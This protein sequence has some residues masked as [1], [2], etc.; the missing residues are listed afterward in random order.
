MILLPLLLACGADPAP[1][2]AE[3]TEVLAVSETSSGRLLFVDWI[4]GTYL[5][6]LCLSELLPEDCSYRSED[7][8]PPCLLFASVP[9]E[10]ERWLLTMA[11]RRATLDYMPGAVLSVTPGRPPQT[12]WRVDSLS[13]AERFPDRYPGCV[14]DPD[15]TLA[16]CRLNSVHAALWDGDTLLVADTVNSRALWLSTPAQGSTTSEVLAIL[17]E[18]HAEW[19]AWRNMNHIQLLEEEGRSLLLTTFKSSALDLWTIDEGRI[20]LW[21]ITDRDAPALVWVYPETGWLA[22][23]HHAEVQTTPDGERWLVYAH[24]LG[25]S[26]DVE[27]GTLGSVG[28]AR[29]EGLSPP[30]YLADGVLED[31]SH[32]LGFVRDVSVEPDGTLLITDSG[33]ENRSADCA[34]EG[35][36]LTAT[37]PALDEAGLSGALGD[38]RFVTLGVS[39]STYDRELVYPY[40]AERF[41]AEALDPALVSGL[42]ACPD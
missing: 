38:Q 24:S 30:T 10:E 40:T 41:A 33:C 20:V 11:R 13:F 3:V 23:P 36:V 34:L 27:T 15:N 21:D 42:G 6:E 16:E 12:H 22:A 19:D 18:D 39:E 26:E 29:W 2:P 7:A 8:D 4:G 31:A 28:I 1:T 5:G 17:G 32:P 35:H 25:A 9:E 37:P 14:D